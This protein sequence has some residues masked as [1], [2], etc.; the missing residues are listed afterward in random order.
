MLCELFCEKEARASEA[1]ASTDNLL[2][3][4]EKESK[5]KA[6]VGKKEEVADLE[7]FVE[8][9]KFLLITMVSSVLKRL[10]FIVARKSLAFFCWQ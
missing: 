4:K 3:T 9:C 5:E 7:E 8:D 1:E 6:L 2:D 10:A